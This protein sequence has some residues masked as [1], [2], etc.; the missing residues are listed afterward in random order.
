[1]SEIEVVET[2]DVDLVLDVL[3]AS[4]TDVP[5]GQF[6]VTERSAMERQIRDGLTLLARIDNEPVGVLQVAFP[7]DKVGYASAA[8]DLFAV[9][10]VAHFDTIAV[11]EPARRR[12]VASALM[13]VAEWTLRTR[14]PGRI[15]W[16]ATVSPDNIASRQLFERA[17]FE[18]SARITIHDALP[19]VLYRRWIEG[20]ARHT[21]RS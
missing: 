7:A 21:V 14:S 20:T 15:A 19:R 16:Y 6:W 3:K 5:P 1:M 2:S 11:I 4:A 17:G 13:S 10:Q 9:D 18:E 8:G 12:G